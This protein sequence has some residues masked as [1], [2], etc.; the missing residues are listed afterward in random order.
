MEL[1]L[2]YI[3]WIYRELQTLQKILDLGSWTCSTLDD[4][5]TH[6]INLLMIINVHISQR[7]EQINAH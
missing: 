3:C 6:V 7:N 4:I 1:W 2:L 5:I